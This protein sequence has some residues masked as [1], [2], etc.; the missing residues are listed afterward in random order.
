MWSFLQSLLLVALEPSEIKLRHSFSQEWLP[1]H[2][3]THTRTQ[4]H[5]QTIT[6]QCMQ[7][8]VHPTG[9]PTYCHW[10][11]SKDCATSC[12]PIGSCTDI[13]C[14]NV[15]KDGVTLS[16]MKLRSTYVRISFFQCCQ[17]SFQTL[18]HMTSQRK[19]EIWGNM[20]VD[21]LPSCQSNLEGGGSE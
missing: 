6:I 12:P 8:S 18:C 1:T 10:S 15:C 19:Q 21:S 20:G 7:G 5:T 4:S 11:Q 2:S 3:H 17:T 9:P 14:T 16:D 13:I